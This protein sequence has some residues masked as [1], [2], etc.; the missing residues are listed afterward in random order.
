MG[1]PW[2]VF[3]R[4]RNFEQEVTHKLAHAI[5]FTSQDENPPQIA[6]S[7]SIRKVK[8]K[9]RQQLNSKAFMVINIWVIIIRLTTTRSLRASSGT[10]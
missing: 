8:R 7:F 2:G 9:G 6:S 5:N 4:P 10:A 3:G 1:V